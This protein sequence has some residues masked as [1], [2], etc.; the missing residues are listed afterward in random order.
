M[1]DESD[2]KE[3]VLGNKQL[4]SIFFIVVAMLGVAFTL[5]YMIGRNT[6]NVSAAGVGRAVPSQ[7]TPMQS[8]NPSHAAEN[9]RSAEPADDPPPVPAAAEPAPEA[10]KQAK[11]TS[12]RAAKPYDSACPGE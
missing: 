4:L 10:P 11:V 12:T 3:L 8:P 1:R 7:A 5:G 9:P 2:E 6:A